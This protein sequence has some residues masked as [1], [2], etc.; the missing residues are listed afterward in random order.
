MTGLS[1]A[2]GGAGRHACTHYCTRR[3]SRLTDS[4]SCCRKGA[5]LVAMVRRAALATSCT[6]PAGATAV[7][8]PAKRHNGGT[9]GDCAPRARGASSSASCVRNAPM[10]TTLNPAS[11]TD[12]H[13][14]RKTACTAST[15]SSTCRKSLPTRGVAARA[16]S[17]PLWPPTAPKIGTS[18]RRPSSTCASG[19]RRHA[20]TTHGGAVEHVVLVTSAARNRALFAVPCRM[21]TC[22]WAAHT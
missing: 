20:C 9:D 16:P 8:L 17:V 18:R 13:A 3:V 19:V 21:C 6:I 10:F 2:G 15:K 11:C 14:C 22:R 12:S 1:E 7:P 5:G 4:T